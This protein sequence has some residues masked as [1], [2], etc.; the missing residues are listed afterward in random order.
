MPT[1]AKKS[2]EQFSKPDESAGK[3][4][5]E[6]MVEEGETEESGILAALLKDEEEAIAGY[7]K[8]L[9]HFSGKAAD[10]I[11]GIINDEKRH[12]EILKGLWGKS[13]LEAEESEPQA[14]SLTDPDNKADV[15]AMKKLT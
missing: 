4:T 7:E 8:A 15:E 2:F 3:E 14:D 9:S 1:E 6:K 11:N 10:E 12:S 5:A 13:A